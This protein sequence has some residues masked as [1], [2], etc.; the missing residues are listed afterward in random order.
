MNPISPSFPPLSSSSS[1]PPHLFFIEQDLTPV[2]FIHLQY[3]A[4]NP[5]LIPTPTQDLTF[6]FETLCFIVFCFVFVFF[7]FE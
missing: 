5:I 2:R 7:A 1:P 4:P 6:A 3:H